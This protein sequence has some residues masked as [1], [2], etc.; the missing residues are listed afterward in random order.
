VVHGFD[1]WVIGVVLG[2][3]RGRER[4]KTTYP[5]LVKSTVEFYTHHKFSAHYF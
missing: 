2:L 5:R 1:S 3:L 4:F